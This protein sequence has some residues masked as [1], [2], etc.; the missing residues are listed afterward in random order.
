MMGTGWG[1]KDGERATLAY[2]DAD[3]AAIVTDPEML[4]LIQRRDALLAEIAELK[5]RRLMMQALEYDGIL[6]QLLIDLALVSR[7]IRART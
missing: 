3:R 7:D 4:R 1:G 6:E 5:K 2:L